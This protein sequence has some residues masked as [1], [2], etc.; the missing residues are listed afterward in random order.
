MNVISPVDV[1]LGEGVLYNVTLK[2]RQWA[3]ENR[4]G[5]NFILDCIAAPLSEPSYPLPV[6]TGQD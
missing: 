4:P 6:S 5:N 1:G 3:E 2:I